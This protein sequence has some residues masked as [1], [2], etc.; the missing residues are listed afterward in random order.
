MVKAIECLSLAILTLSCLPVSTLILLLSYLYTSVYPWIPVHQRLS[1]TPGY[2]SRTILITGVISPYGLRLARAFHRTGHVVIGADREHG[3]LPSHVRF[4]R[5]LT[6]FYQLT[7]ETGEARAA[8]HIAHIVRHEHVDLWISCSSSANLSVEAQASTIIRQNTECQCFTL[9]PDEMPYL[10]SRET[11]ME[12]LA[13]Q[14]LPVPESYQVTSRAEIHDVLSKSRG[15]S[16]ISSTQ[17][18]TQR[19][20]CQYSQNHAP[21]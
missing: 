21:E 13:D 16:E 12:Y 2:K 14:G 18:R 7:T 15:K 1:R 19:G 20:G 5:A 8:K 10:E 17:S 4:S 11:F 3:G 6:R 9:L